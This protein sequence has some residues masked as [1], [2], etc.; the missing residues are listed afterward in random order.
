MKYILEIV[1]FK[2]GHFKI[3]YRSL[4]EQVLVEQLEHILACSMRTVGCSPLLGACT[5][6]SG[7]IKASPEVQG[8]QV[9][10]SSGIF[11]SCI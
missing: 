4:L 9:C 6:P 11:E 8:I 5:V 1:Y 2:S 10:P 3:R 7:P